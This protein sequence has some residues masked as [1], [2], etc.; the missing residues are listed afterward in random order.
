MALAVLSL[1][2]SSHA[3]RPRGLRRKRPRS[4]RVRALGRRR[5]RL[6]AASLAALLG[7]LE[8]AARGR[9]GLGRGPLCRAQIY[10]R[11]DTALEHDGGARLVVARCRVSTDAAICRVLGVFG[12]RGVHS[13]RVKKKLYSALAAR[14]GRRSPRSRDQGRLLSGANICPVSPFSPLSNSSAGKSNSSARSSSLCSLT[15]ASRRARCAASSMYLSQFWR[16]S[17]TRNVSPVHT[18]P[19]SMPSQSPATPRRAWIARTEPSG[20]P[21]TTYPRKLHSAPKSCRPAPRSTPCAAPCNESKMCIAATTVSAVA[22]CETTAGSSVY[23]RGRSVRLSA[24]NVA[25]TE[26]VQITSPMAH[27]AVRCAPTREPAPN[28]FPVSALVAIATPSGTM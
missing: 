19:T 17:T 26:P 3:Q 16:R 6:H 11:R 14:S 27:T 12:L 13:P 10:C 25:S 9:G 22:T 8:P 24:R 18:T 1:R 7:V 15:T 23:T 5:G 4:L 20:T 2:V 28:M 21:S